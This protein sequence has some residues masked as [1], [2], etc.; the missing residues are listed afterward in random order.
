[1]YP[2]LA[3]ATP[4]RY[5]SDSAVVGPL[6]EKFGTETAQMLDGKFSLAVYDHRTGTLYAARDHMG[7]SPLYVGYG[8]EV[9]FTNPIGDPGIH[10]ACDRVSFAEL[11]ALHILHTVRWRTAP[12]RARCFSRAR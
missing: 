3:S 1:M 6:F 4:H 5:T 11:M 2:F 12:R 7:I 9:R 10:F 8:E